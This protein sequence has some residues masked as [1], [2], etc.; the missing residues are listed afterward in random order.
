[1][2]TRDDLRRLGDLA[3][4]KAARDRAAL[5]AVEARAAPIRAALARLDAPPPEAA[6]DDLREARDRAAWS[7]W[8]GTERRRLQ[9]DLA[10]LRA[11]LDG[12]KRL[13]AKATAREAVIGKLRDTAP[14]R[15]R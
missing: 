2:T 7:A 10:R 14:P 4:L 9:M 12:A 13:A 8:A 5:A 6:P 3:A 1:M 15:R 11:E